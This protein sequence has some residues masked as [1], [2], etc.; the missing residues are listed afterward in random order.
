MIGRWWKAIC[1]ILSSVVRPRISCSD[2]SFIKNSPS[3]FYL[4]KST[5]SYGMIVT[6]G[7]YQTEVGI[8]LKRANVG[9]TDRIVTLLTSVGKLVA[10]ARGVRKVTSRKASHLELFQQVTVHLAETKGLPIIQEAV[11]QVSYP[12]LRLDLDAAGQ[13][14]WAAELIDRLVGDQAGGTLYPYLVTYLDR[15]NK[16]AGPLDIRAFELAVLAELGWQPE[17][18]R[19]AHCHSD[20]TPASLGWSHAH[21]GV[22]DQACCESQGINHHISQDAVK[23]LRLLASQYLNVSHRLQVSELVSTEIEVLLKNYLTS[24]SERPWKSLQLFHT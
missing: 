10:V 11:T 21:G 6:M 15:V 2:N 16:G 7:R 4:T 19:C 20:L 23:A 24:I 5:A 8:V 13:A 9:E 1:W 22:L 17:L 3:V 18:H 14:F 12:R